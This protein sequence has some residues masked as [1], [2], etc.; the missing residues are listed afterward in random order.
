MHAR[1]GVRVGVCS[2]VNLQQL[3]AMATVKGPLC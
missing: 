2:V 3:L 1:V